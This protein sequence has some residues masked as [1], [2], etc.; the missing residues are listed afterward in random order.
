MKRSSFVPKIAVS[1]VFAVFAAVG[2]GGGG[3]GSGANGG[4]INGYDVNLSSL[5][6]SSGTLTPAFDQTVTAYTVTVDTAV[7]S[8]K[9]KPSVVDKNAAITVNGSAIDSGSDS[10]EISLAPGVLA[11]ISIT[12]VAPDK[13]T[14][15]TYTV[16]A[17]RQ[18]TAPPASVNLS[19]LSL[20]AGTISPSFDPT[21]VSYTATV[22][23][24]VSSVSVNAVALDTKALVRIN[25]STNKTVPLAVGVNAIIVKV[26]GYDGN[27][28][29][30]Y[31]I[32]VIRGAPSTNANLSDLEISKGTL[33]PEFDESKY[34][35][36]ASVASAVSSVSV[37]PTAED[38]GSTI[39][40]N[41][42]TV[43]S[44]SSVTISLPVNS[45]TTITVAVTAQDG[46]AKNSY[47]I[48]MTRAAVSANANLSSLV[49]SNGTLTPRFDPNTTFYRAEIATSQASSTITPTVSYNA[50]SVFVNGSAVNSGS[51]SSSIP[52]NIGVN[53]ASVKVIAENGTEKTY[54]VELVRV[55]D[56]S[57]NAFLA[58]LYLSS[59]S[60]SPVFCKT[61]TAYTAEVASNI[62]SITVTPS[63][64]G[65]NAAVK[66]NGTAVISNNASLPITL[67]AGANTITVEVWAEDTSS[68]MKY[69]VT[70]TRLASGVTSSNANGAG[71]ST[72]GG[73]IAP[74][75]DP[76]V[77]GYT[78]YTNEPTYTVTPATAGAG[79][80]V[81]V[82]G[83]A[84][85]SGTTSVTIPSTTNATIV[86]TAANGTT[87]TYTI[88]V[89]KDTTPP[90][91]GTLKAAVAEPRFI[92]L[93]WTASS[94]DH[95]AA[96]NI[97]Y[98]VYKSA[99]ADISTVSNAE[100]NGALITKVSGKCLSTAAV[101]LNPQTGYYFTIV[102]A[103]QAGNKAVYPVL[104]ATTT[105]AFNSVS[106]NGWV[107]AIAPS[108]DGKTIYVGGR[109]TSAGKFFAHSGTFDG[110]NSALSFSHD[111][112]GSVH[113]SASDGE[114]GWYIGG[115][116][117]VVLGVT[118]NK[119]AH[120]LSD[121]SLD[122]WNPDANRTVMTLAISGSTVYAGGDFTA[123]GGT[124]RNLLAAMDA[125]T[126][127]LANW[128][129]SVSNYVRTLAISGNTVYV[130]GFFWVN[131]EATG[132]HLAAWDATTGALKSWNPN[133]SSQVD[134]LAISGSTLYA[135]G[136]FTAIGGT[137]RNH[138]AAWDMTTGEL[139]SW[140]P[141]V[142]NHVYTLAI[143]G[144]TVYAGGYFT[145]IGVTTRNSLAAID[146]ST[147]DLKSWNPNAGPAANNE[148]K[149]L[150]ISGNT[151][152]AGGWFST[153]GGTTRRNLAAMDAI[154]G[155]LTSWNPNA[156]DDVYTLAISENTVYAGG[157]F[158]AI[159][160]TTRQFLAAMDAS[161][162]ALTDWNPLPLRPVNALAISGNTIYAGGD[163]TNIGGTSEYNGE[164]WVIIGGTT[165]NYLAAMD[166]STGDL[167]N[168]NPDANNRVYA[169]AIS[170]DT[171]YAGGEFTAI[172]GITRNGLAAWDV[173]TGD[174][175][176]WN[177]NADPTANNGVKALAISGNTV[178]TGGYLWTT[179]GTARNYLA[180]WDVSTGTLT[181]W[182]QNQSMNDSIY[183]LATS[184]NTVYVGGMFNSIG[185]YSRANFAAVDATTGRPK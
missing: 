161:T 43:T 66:V 137:T 42:T 169:L 128:N 24:A 7:T 144:D 166:A 185:N 153:I 109:F 21:N 156:D 34:S 88:T 15:K 69:V 118:R 113:A 154:T 102:A 151:V 133:V 19:S 60:L 74:A 90:T 119:L 1:L 12:V 41:G 52:L 76:S 5:E 28:V 62:T 98:T 121:G 114:G 140:N 65:L 33:S 108:N 58:G 71:L 126:G 159:G 70:V 27:T 176:S 165:R 39:A 63:A 38:S 142:N 163:F 130:G 87:K 183:A 152:Y 46:T 89:V 164:K 115:D 14:K 22:G 26:F 78:L 160:G 61:K 184:G 105:G 157:Q 141:D 127:A 148:V 47:V 122:E 11:N 150:A 181:G 31:L 29:K 178:Y 131:G 174:L 84:V 53:K 48:N 107:S 132:R 55:P 93:A 91:V 57:K 139:K 167:K 129:P 32:S 135:G 111:V 95:S 50:A 35:Y 170:G 45:T 92:S 143:S 146:A 106:I 138:L 145:A 162:G 51:A 75:F 123:I 68:Y 101:R 54:S 83:T 116:F 155:D 179:G 6:I 3:G 8:I 175:K 49:I 67:S 134:S 100:T 124:T 173:P 125:S 86:V 37:T 64:A 171:V 16:V 73:T 117:T 172:G 36:N 82:N 168:W 79:S 20:S 80:S 23:Y 85:T 77:T 103:D 2:C 56:K 158:F 30:E 17:L 94:D 112:N 120:I 177:P 136:S 10:Q 180:A 104:N 96:D 72:D 97:S 99:G 182:Y 40:V 25:G 4:I 18:G 44:G 9:V 81:T 13:T 110:S 59:G 149:A 147:G